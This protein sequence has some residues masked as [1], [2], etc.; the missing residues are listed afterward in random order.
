MS[1]LR[2]NLASVREG[3]S[4]P[5]PTLPSSPPSPK[6]DKC[7]SNLLQILNAVGLAVVL[8]QQSDVYDFSTILPS[9][10]VEKAVHL[11]T[12]SQLVVFGSVAL[13]KN[14]IPGKDDPENSPKLIYLTGKQRKE[15]TVAKY[16]EAE[17]AAFTQSSRLT[18]MAVLFAHYQL[19]L[20]AP[21]S[22]LVFGLLR[23][24]LLVTNPLFQV[25]VLR[26]SAVGDL[27]RPWGIG[28]VLVSQETSEETAVDTTKSVGADASDAKPAADANS[29]GK[30]SKS[31][32]NK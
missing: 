3:L 6:G 8:V 27:H 10:V 26:W 31:N 18:F 30:R 1:F 16:D 19:K 24:V 28:E 29:K 11:Y 22:L 23:F 4:H 9:I 12:L 2:G 14:G 5:S 13:I 20:V 7:S 17:C 32:K 21:V 15:T 25:Y